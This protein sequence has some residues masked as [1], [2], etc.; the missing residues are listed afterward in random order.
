MLNDQQ[1]EK[2]KQQ[3]L[4]ASSGSVYAVV[5]GASCPDLRF[6][7]FE[8]Q[9]QSCCLWSGKLAPDMEE[10]AP[11]LV[12]LHSDSL[13]TDWLIRYGWD[14]HWNIFVDSQLP[15]KAL[16]KQ[17]R[18]LLLVKSPEGESLTFRYYDPRVMSIFI[19][20]CESH[21][22]EQ[23]F[24]NIETFL[25]QDDVHLMRAGFSVVEKQVVIDEVY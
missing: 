3:L 15:F 11:Y 18:K 5:D 12:K 6:K 9:P 2:I 8:W 7:L 1:V 19:P 22:A 13:L 16:R 24:Q 21:Q 20:T 14:H 4:N 23:L 17:L 10:V 25:Y